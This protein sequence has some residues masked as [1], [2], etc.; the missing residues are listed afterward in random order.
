MANIES[1][2]T[3]LLEISA[4]ALKTVTEGSTFRVAMECLSPV[5]PRLCELIGWYLLYSSTW[6]L[7]DLIDV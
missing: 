3:E 5:V 2:K 4:L 1:D 7:Y 6:L